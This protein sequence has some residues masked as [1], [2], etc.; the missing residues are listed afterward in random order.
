MTRLTTPIEQV[1]HRQI[2]DY[3][4]LQYPDVIFNSDGAG[5]HQPSKTM[6]GMNAMLRS[7]RGY[8]DIFIAEPTAIFHGMFLEVKREGIV[9]MRADGQLVAKEHLREQF[10]LL[11]ALKAKGYYA[12][13][14]FGFDDAREKIDAYMLAR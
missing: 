9:V 8:P 13:F 2:C 1:V 4:R 11:E 7:R 12:A 6:R 3:M 14:A 5:N 10:Y